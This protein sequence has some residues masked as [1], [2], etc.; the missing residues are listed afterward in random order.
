MVSRAMKGFKIEVSLAVVGCAILCAVRLECKSE[1]SN[2][3]KASELMQDEPSNLMSNEPA[4]IF[5]IFLLIAIKFQNDRPVAICHQMV[6]KEEIKTGCVTRRIV[7]I[8]IGN[9]LV[10]ASPIQNNKQT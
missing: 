6:L 5:P 8:R 2:Q 7:S 10:G 9:A 3:N 4:S 1:R